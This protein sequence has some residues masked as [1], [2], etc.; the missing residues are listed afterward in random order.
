[1]KVF[2]SLILGV[3]LLGLLVLPGFWLVRAFNLK[4]KS[5][6]KLPMKRYILICLALSI[7]LLWLMGVDFEGAALP[8][9]LT[10]MGLNLALCV[11]FIPVYLGGRSI[12]AF[13]GEKPKK[14]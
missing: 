12:V 4:V 5:S 7:G 2:V 6:Q 1:M 10:L 9:V 8:W 3:L 11:L 13:L 14:N